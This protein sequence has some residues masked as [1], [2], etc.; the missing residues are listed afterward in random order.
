MSDSNE[1]AAIH[2]RLFRTLIIGLGAVIAYSEIRIQL[3][4]DDLNKLEDRFNIHA[5]QPAHEGASASTDLLRQLVFWVMDQVGISSF[6]S[7]LI[8]TN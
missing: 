6:P 4:I 5:S 3:L 2:D 8:P 7:T 1:N